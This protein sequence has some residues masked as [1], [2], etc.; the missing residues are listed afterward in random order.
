MSQQTYFPSISKVRHIPLNLLGCQLRKC[1]QG[2]G[3]IGRTQTQNRLALQCVRCA[4]THRVV[5]SSTQG[6]DA[7]VLDMCCLVFFL[8]DPMRIALGLEEAFPRV[9]PECHAASARCAAQPWPPPVPE[10][11]GAALAVRRTTPRKR[12]R[13]CVA[14]LACAAWPAQPGARP[15]PR[16][17]GPQGLS[18]STPCAWRGCACANPAG[19]A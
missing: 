8:R 15:T 11:R 5:L 12:G 18:S 10:L 1:V 17:P 2:F 7:D 9:S 6:N 3:G 19:A 4:S 14:A 16:T 13:A